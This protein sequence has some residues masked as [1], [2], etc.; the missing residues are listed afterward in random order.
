MS[1]VQSAHNFDIADCRKDFPALDQEIQN[2]LDELGM[3]IKAG[4]ISVA[5]LIAVGI[6]M[7]SLTMTELPLITGIVGIGMA[8]NIRT[9]G[10]VARCA[11]QV[12]MCTFQGKS[13]F[14]M[15]LEI[16]APF[17]L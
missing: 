12:D 1:T 6:L 13:K 5:E 10:W 7:T 8:F 16:N 2:Q 15:D 3:T 17:A 11:G 4:G 14:G 9:I